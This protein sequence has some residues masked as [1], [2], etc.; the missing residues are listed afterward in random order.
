MQYLRSRAWQILQADGY[1]SS[2]D[3]TRCIVQACFYNKQPTLTVGYAR[4]AAVSILGNSWI[5]H[6]DALSTGDSHL[7]SHLRTMGMLT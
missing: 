1:L 4:W 2:G 3:L 7:C 6:H 5:L